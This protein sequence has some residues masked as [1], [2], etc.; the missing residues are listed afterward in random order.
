MASVKIFS[1]LFRR[2]D[3]RR[4]AKADILAVRHDDD[5]G[6]LINGKYYSPLIDSILDE[7]KRCRTLTVASPYSYRIK[8]SSYAGALNFNGAF[9]RE[10]LV[11]RLRSK[12]GLK[13]DASDLDTWRA[14]LRVV[15]PR[16]VISIQ[17]HSALCRA[18]HELGV[19]VFDVQHGYVGPKNPGYGEEFQIGRHRQE[20]AD[21]ILCWDNES[22]GS[23]RDWTTR[24]QIAL[25][26]IGN[27]WVNKF[28]NRREEDNV[29][30]Y[31]A[32]KR[33]S[34]R[35]NGARAKILVSLQ[36]GL[37]D[38]ATAPDQALFDNEFMPI[39]LERA[40]WNTRLD[41][42]WVL[43]PH[44]TQY[45]NPV[46]FKRLIAHVKERFGSNAIVSEN[47]PLPFVL[48]SVDLHITYNSSVVI[49][50]EYFGV[51]SA[52]L[53]PQINGGLW[54]GYFSSQIGKGAARLLPCQASAIQD[55][56]LVMRAD[57]RAKQRVP[58]MLQA[59]A[60]FLK[61]LDGH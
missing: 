46:V 33:S 40:I 30:R 32:S 20:M 10:L 24:K 54:A 26:V 41:Y 53:D 48:S 14:V 18:C 1:Q 60:E 22:A 43:R 12:L 56:I 52:L 16:Y 45:L 5:C 59:Y 42:D 27:P 7:L 39:E 15:Q 25:R 35:H 44:P 37:N 21:C 57:L 49:E 4:L 61:E 36:W 19:Y 29:I 11:N 9:M 34:D 47:E 6:Q 58:A 31:F 2:S 8:D 13:S 17:P 23:I 50:A 51:P 3:W 55:W 38:P 28:V